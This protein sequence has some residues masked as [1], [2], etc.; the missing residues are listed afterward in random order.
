MTRSEMTRSEMTRSERNRGLRATVL[1]LLGVVMVTSVTGC[2]AAHSLLGIHEAPAART[3]STP[4]TVDRARMILTRSF[5]A[6]QQG[7]TLSG[8]AAAGAQRTAYTGEGLRAA[9][10]RVRL[11]SLTSRTAEY[12]L[13]SPERP[14]LLAVSRG[15]A[16]PRFIVAQTVT[17][18]GGVPVVHLL[19]SPDAAT[20]YRIS[21]SAEMVPLAKVT[22]F[23]PLNQGS[24]LV[25][26]G[27]GL[28]VAPAA[29]LSTYAQSMAFPAKPVSNLPFTTDSFSGQLRAQAAGVAKAVA[30]QATFSQVHKV[31]AG[32][33]YAVRQ[34]SGDVLVFGVIRRTDSFA[35]KAGQAV[36][37]AGNKAFVLLTGKK[38]VTK[39]ASVTTLEFVVFSVPRSSGR[40]TLVAVREQVVAGS[41]S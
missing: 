18:K 37:T 3:A 22:P 6:A 27:S 30:A 40:A 5:T 15:F 7:E 19:T 29:L 17:S 14:R 24:P 35:V 39:T 41:G 26:G 11:V 36:N 4:L 25:T 1:S 32:S 2:G 28:A 21:V 8:A 38:K 13:L 23:D 10:A 9:H 12:S 33:S 34:A 20:P 31:V 16:F